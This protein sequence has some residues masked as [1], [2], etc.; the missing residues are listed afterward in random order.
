MA[1]S[2]TTEIKTTPTLFFTPGAWHDP[3]VFD[4]V[5][6]ILSAR[7]FE[8]ETSSLATVGSVDPSVGMC[9]DAAKIRSALSNLINEGKEVILVA[10]SYGGIV[11][12]NAVDGLGIEQRTS[13]SLNGSI[14]MILYLAAFVVPAGTDLK[15]NLG[16]SYPPWWNI[17][18]GGFITPMKPQDVFCADVEASLASKAVATLKPMPLQMAK[19]IS[20]Y[21]PRD[22]TF[23]VGYI[24]AEKDQAIPIGAQN[25]MFSQFPVG[26][27]A[28]RLDSSH[29]PF[30]SMP[31]TLADTIERATKYVLA[32]R[33]T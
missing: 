25:A 6:S 16:G 10:H 15:T 1:T 32:K 27:F 11:A 7:G 26:S 2:T 4:S 13:N 28:A 21:D 31:N 22:G 19:D 33:S 9:S 8:T 17:S 18:M 29:S 30:L 23:E 14:I 5:R 24:F 20:T 3:W 12:S